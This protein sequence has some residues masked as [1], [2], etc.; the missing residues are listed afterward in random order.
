MPVS[1]DHHEGVVDFVGREQLVIHQHNR[2]H[3]LTPP[4]HHVPFA[5]SPALQFNIV[6]APAE[7][8]LLIVVGS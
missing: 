3:R 8:P 4:G 7:R 1:A 2:T 6:V 5:V